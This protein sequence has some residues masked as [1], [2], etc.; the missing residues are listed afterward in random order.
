MNYFVIFSLILQLFK[1]NELPVIQIFMTVTRKQYPNHIL[2][3]SIYIYIYIF[4]SY[5]KQEVK[6]RVDAFQN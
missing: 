6:N 5:S 1:R 3:A 4:Q 2:K